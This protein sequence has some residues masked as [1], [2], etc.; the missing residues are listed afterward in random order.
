MPGV[1]SGRRFRA[2][3]AE[4]GRRYL[5]PYHMRDADVSRSEAWSEASNTPWTMWMRPNRLDLRMIRYQ[6]QA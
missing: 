5:A 2:T 4:S 3:D 1:L 6:R